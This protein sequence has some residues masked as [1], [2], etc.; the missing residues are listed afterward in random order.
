METESQ[1]SEPS[2]SISVTKSG[3]RSLVGGGLAAVCFFL[4]W[5]QVSCMGQTQTLSGNQIA[6]EK[7][8]VWLVL[9]AAIAIVVIT[10]H[11]RS[12]GKMQEGRKQI[13][14]AS[15]IGL[16]IIA[17]NYLQFKGGIDTPQ[18]RMSA[19]MLNLSWQLGVFGTIAGFLIALY[20]A[21]SGTDVAAGTSSE[22]RSMDIAQTARGLEQHLS[23]LEGEAVAQ[24]RVAA[25]NASAGLDSLRKEGETAF[26]SAGGWLAEHRRTVVLTG[27][28]AAAVVVTGFIV[29]PQPEKD[30]SKV[31]ASFTR[32]RSDYKAE[33]EGV[34]RRILEKMSRER[35]T[36][37]ALVWSELENG[38]KP[39]YAFRDKC[40]SDAN[41]QLA[42]LSSRWSSNAEKQSAFFAAT[43]EIRTED[44]AG[45]QGNDLT[46][47]FVS[48]LPTFM[49]LKALIDRIR[50]APPGRQRI[51][52]DLIGHTIDSWRFA[53]LSEFVQTTVEKTVAAGDSLDFRLRL[54]MQDGNTHAPYLGLVIVRYVIDNDVWRF[55]KVRALLITDQPGIDYN[56]N[57]QLFPIGRWRLADHYATFLPDGSWTGTWDDGNTASGEWRIVKGNLVRTRGGSTWQSGRILSFT[58]NEINLDLGW[59]NNVRAERVN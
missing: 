18:G 38:M 42:K 13:A 25:A 44:F 23:A 45:I 16:G 30:A 3:S 7:G 48:T 46:D 1:K 9:I 24:A 51:E 36:S 39:A 55:Q 28:V 57:G 5:I 27:A 56:V 35:P 59:G 47:N 40:L 26:R 15:L 6:S 50:P 21:I 12:T 8:I 43:N 34:H 29:R 20:D 49:P 32:C 19:A 54:D 31:V 10:L 11:Y 33:V 37:R 14:I 22:V 58:E 17:W 41:A 2:A 4:P 52:Q 53:Y